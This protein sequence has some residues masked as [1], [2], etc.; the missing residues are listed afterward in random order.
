MAKVKIFVSYS[1]KDQRYRDE[2]VKHLYLLERKGLVSIWSEGR[3]AAGM[4]WSDEVRRAID[5]SDIAI[6][7]ISPDYLAS[8]YVVDH[9]LPALLDNARERGRVILPVMV[10]A[11]PWTTVPELAQ[12]QFL[13][14]PSKPLASARDRDEALSRVAQKLYELV[15]E[16]SARS[17]TEP[18]GAPSATPAHSAAQGDVGGHLFL[19][20]SKEDG[21]FAE[22]LKLRLEQI[23]FAAWIDTDRLEPGLDWRQEIDQSIRSSIA[24]IAIMS[25]DARSSEY[26]TYEWAFA[27]GAGKRIVPIMLRQTSL[28]P[29][30]ATLQYVDFTNRSAR[31]WSKLY[32][33][34]RTIRAAPNTAAQPD[35]YA[36]GK[37]RSR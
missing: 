31:P 13:N 2:L 1:H 23:G 5:E 3:I 10:R 8:E 14:E 24:V 16:V 36:A 28:H 9:E 35:S 37:R 18:S 11:A 26:V 33:L 19:S 21:D 32:D 22:L 7:L 6:V 30:L 12:Y 25:P 4:E 34:L 17:E 29:R 15:S 20:H 27:W